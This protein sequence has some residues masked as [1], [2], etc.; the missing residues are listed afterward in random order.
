[1]TY[2]T[3]A[4]FNSLTGADEAMLWTYQIPTPGAAALLALGGLV[5]SRRRRR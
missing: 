1:M 3:G 5:V 2:V 4:A